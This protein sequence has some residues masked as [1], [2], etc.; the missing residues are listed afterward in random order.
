MT[1]A[2]AVRLGRVSNLPT[3]W[4]N[5]L[6]GQALAGALLTPAPLALL[7]IGVSLAYV[8][9]MYLN[10]AFDAEIDARERPE[11]PIPSG[12]VSRPAVFACGYAMLAAS[13]LFLAATGAMSGTGPWPA[14]AG[15]VLAALIVA[16]NWRHKENPVGPLVMGLCRVL[17]YFASALAVTVGLTPALL[18][19]A[20]LLLS[21]LI[22]LTYLA[23]QETLGRIA[24][25][26]PLLFLGAAIVYGAALIVRE[27]YAAFF[28]L[29]LLMS[30]GASLRFTMRRGPG[31]IQRSV[32]VLIA[33]ISLLDALLI[34][35]QGMG[36]LA[37][38]AAFGFPATIVA[39]RFVKGT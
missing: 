37:F 16:Y 20:G 10:D 31:D 27:P 11:R 4:T 39:Q 28:W 36:D 30:L 19:G 12:R 5:A 33:A 6:A 1:F 34:A 38:L 8:G 3:V 18:I 26:W 23:K 14:L 25:L 15:L 24:N 9:G 17:V 7:L 21:H 29:L 35:G 13:V 22:G 2:D 32:T